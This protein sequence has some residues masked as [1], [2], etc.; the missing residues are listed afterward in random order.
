MDNNG[1]FTESAISQKLHRM[2]SGMTDGSN[3]S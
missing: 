2:I 3:K 1:Y